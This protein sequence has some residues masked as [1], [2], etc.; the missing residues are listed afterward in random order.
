[1]LVDD[2][3]SVSGRD[4]QFEFVDELYVVG[5]RRPAQGERI[6]REYYLSTGRE[7]PQLFGLGSICAG[8]NRLV[9][10]GHLQDWV[11]YSVA[12]LE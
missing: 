6:N 8:R 2:I 1:M 12:V 3:R 4:L 9:Q 7:I 5:Q 11:S 10:L